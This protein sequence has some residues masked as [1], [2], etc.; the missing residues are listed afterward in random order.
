M[1]GTVVNVTTIVDRYCG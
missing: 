1:I